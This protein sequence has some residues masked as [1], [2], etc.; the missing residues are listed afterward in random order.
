[1]N[2]FR[3]TA[4]DIEVVTFGRVNLKALNNWATADDWFSPLAPGQRGRS[5]LFSRMNMIESCVV[6]DMMAAG[7]TRKEVKTYLTLTAARGRAAGYVSDLPKRLEASDPF[8]PGSNGWFWLI[9]YKEGFGSKTLDELKI[10]RSDDIVK[11]L[12]DAQFSCAIIPL[13]AVIARVDAVTAV[14]VE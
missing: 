7:S 10:C 11:Y 4:A 14:A 2:E 9:V 13:S 12:A 3:Y 1:M 5:R 6:A 8:R